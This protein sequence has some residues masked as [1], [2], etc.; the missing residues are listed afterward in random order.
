MFFNVISY[1]IHICRMKTYILKFFIKFI[2]HNIDFH[3]FYFFAFRE[4]KLLR[5]PEHFELFFF[6]TF[7]TTYMLLNAGFVIW[8]I[9]SNSAK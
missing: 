8:N 2:T 5:H 9:I 1:V 7:F 3:Y 4:K 6:C